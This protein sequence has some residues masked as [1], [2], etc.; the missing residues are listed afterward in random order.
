MCHRLRLALF[1]IFNIGFSSIYSQVSQSIVGVWQLGSYQVAGGLLDNYRFYENKK[2][3]FRPND[4]DGLNRTISLNGRYEVMKDSLVLTIVSV[5]E[6]VG[7]I[8]T[9]SLTAGG[10]GWEIMGGKVKI[11]FLR[12]E[13]RCTLSIGSCEKG[14]SHQCLLIDL[15]TFYKVKL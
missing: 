6:L 14:E 11:H 9:R 13:E 1:V 12:K 10:S 15:L 2:F 3:E 7:G 4:N 8:P 5:T